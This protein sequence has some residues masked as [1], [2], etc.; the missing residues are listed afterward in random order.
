MFREVERAGGIGTRATVG[1]VGV[2]FAVGWNIAALGAIATRLAHAYGVGLAT[3]GLFTTAQFV[4]HLCMQVPAGRLADRFGARRVGLGATATLAGA[5]ALAL[6]APHVWLALVAKALCGFGTGL[7]FVGGSDYV[8]AAGGSALAP[9][10]YG[11]GPGAAPGPP[12]AP[13]PAL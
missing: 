10:V 13:L 3:I 11:G 8:R 2:G 4:V 1:G 12:P 5:N 9:G 6:I 7:G